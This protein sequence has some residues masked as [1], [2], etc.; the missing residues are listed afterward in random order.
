[1]HL[2]HSHAKSRSD[3]ITK[4]DLLRISSLSETCLCS[5]RYTTVTYDRCCVRSWSKCTAC[6]LLWCAVSSCWLIKASLA[7]ISTVHVVCMT[8]F[9][10]LQR[11]L[12]C[13]YCILLWAM[14]CN[15]AYT[16]GFEWNVMEYSVEHGN[17]AARRHFG[18]VFT[19]LA[20]AAWQAAHLEWGASYLVLEGATGNCYCLQ[21]VYMYICF[22][23]KL[24]NEFFCHCPLTS[25]F[26]LFRKWSC[27]I[28]PACCTPP[29]ITLVFQWKKKCVFIMWL[30]MLF[31]TWHV[32]IMSET[33]GLILRGIW[34]FICVYI[35]WFCRV[36]CTATVKSK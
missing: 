34:N 7:P 8:F 32:H 9:F 23:A 21:I 35:R 18:A 5:A 30:N 4:G 15:S 14:S 25:K 31:A 17:R 10:L 27:K 2:V 1:M 13:L 24:P 16:A 11:Q 28:Y 29:N 22:E 3:G 26:I 33:S 20:E 6:F 12:F 36:W 19:L